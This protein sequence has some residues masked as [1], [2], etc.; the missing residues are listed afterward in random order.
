VGL[1]LTKRLGLF[2]FPMIKKAL[3]RY[4]SRTTTRDP[5]SL[6]E[7]KF[8]NAL[9]LVEICL[10]SSQLER[11]KVVYDSLTRTYPELTK[12][13]VDIHTHNSFLSSYVNERNFKGCLKHFNVIKKEIKPNATSYSILLDGALSLNYHQF[14]GVILRDMNRNFIHVSKCLDE[15]SISEETKKLILQQ[16]EKES[17]PR[18][19]SST[20]S[21]QSDFNTNTLN[22][23]SLDLIKQNL[24]ALSSNQEFEDL[25]EL[26]ERIESE[27][28]FS[29]LDRFQIHNEKRKDI[30]GIGYISKDLKK[31][32]SSWNSRLTD[33]LKEEFN[34]LEGKNFT[35]KLTQSGDAHEILPFLDMFRNHP[36]ILSTVVISVILREFS[37]KHECVAVGLCDSIGKELEKE[38]RTRIYKKYRS[39][40]SLILI[41]RKLE[42]IR[43]SSKCFMKENILILV[44][45]TKHLFSMNGPQTYV[46]L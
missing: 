10:N 36:E 12:K 34:T 43:S 39:A 20:E 23:K 28:F 31:L 2:K 9:S 19:V 24:A 17:Q 18:R 13:Y 40:V 44:M 5:E 3:N 32:A 42:N 37:Q 7:R 26:Q 41:Y 11:A 14:F 30:S 45:K 8:R 33:I 6:N 22:K 38:H 46:L 35:G 15:L 29:G 25:I 1:N 4:F 27:T 16:I 21:P